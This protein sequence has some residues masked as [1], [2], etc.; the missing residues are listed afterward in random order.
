MTIA[1]AIG[2]ALIAT[3]GSVATALAT[4]PSAPKI[5]AP[6]PQVIARPNNAISDALAKRRGV[7][8]N[9][10]TGSG[11]AESATTAKKTFMGN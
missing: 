2:A 8:A 4:K 5:M 7:A 11:G 9:Q 1:P 10:V 6:T 3:A